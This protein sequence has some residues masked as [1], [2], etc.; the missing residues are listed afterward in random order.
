MLRKKLKWYRLFGTIEDLEVCLAG[1]RV[2]KHQTAFGTYMIGKDAGQYV[3]F[4]AKCPHQN[5][6]LD[7]CQVKDGHVVCP[8][9]QYQFSLEHGRGH[10]LYL[11]RYPLRIDQSGVFIGVE[12]WT[13][14]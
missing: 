1:K 4:S 14:F 11:E 9:H 2:A 7:D 8:Y 12:K 10:G 13:F 5:K 3:A 6:P